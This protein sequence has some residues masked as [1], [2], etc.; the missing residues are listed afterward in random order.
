MGYDVLLL[1]V[2]ALVVY[3][4]VLWAHS[5]RH[6]FGPVHFYALMGGITAVMSWVTDAGLRVETAGITFNVGSTLF[7]TSLLLGVFVIYVFDGPRTTRLLISTI[8]AVSV[9]MPLIAMVL[10]YQNTLLTGGPLSNVPM[11]SLR[12]NAASVVATLVDLVFLAIV[13]EFLG[14]PALRVKLWMRTFLTL[15]GVMW[16]DVLLFTTGAFWGTPLYWSIMGGTLLGRFC[17]SVLAF[18][19]LYL[20]LHWQSRHRSVSIENRP[21]LS[22]LRQI[23][24]ISEEL[25]QAQQEIARRQQVEAKLHKALSE[26]KTLRGFIPICAGCKKVRDDKGYW[27]QIESYLQRHSDARFSHGLCADCMAKYYPSLQDGKG[28]DVEPAPGAPPA[29]P[30][31]PPA[32]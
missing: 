24:V 3:A 8:V 28:G 32:R 14:Q 2:E 30:A 4:A 7:Y 19:V 31:A 1:I 29:T 13:W 23:A 21:V 15:L 16:L 17:I 20:Y 18:P 9:M 25:S 10:H 27:E 6:R 11:P 26:V 12:I 22:I 5:L